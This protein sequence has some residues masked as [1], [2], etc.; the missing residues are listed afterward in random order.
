[1][2]HIALPWGNQMKSVLAIA[3]LMAT[4]TAGYAGTPIDASGVAR[5]TSANKQEVI[6]KGHVLVQSLATYNSFDAKDPGNPLNGMKG[7]C[8]GALEIKV[9]A[10]TGQGYCTFTTP[11]GDKQFSAWVAQNLGP[12]GA[13]SGTWKM[14]SGTG[15]LAGATGGGTFSTVADPKTKA[16]TNTIKG[17]MMLR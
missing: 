1:M 15:K 16:V 11:S 17:T 8:W 4:A 3:V 14:L 7:R 10:V 6:G 5:G 9:P 2:P 12:K 13:I